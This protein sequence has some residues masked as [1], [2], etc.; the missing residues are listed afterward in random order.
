MLHSKLHKSN[1]HTA[2]SESNSSDSGLDSIASH[3]EPFQG[4]FVL[5][6]TFAA[7]LDTTLPQTCFVYNTSTTAV[8]IS[9]AHYSL[10]V[11]GDVVCDGNLTIDSLTLTDN[12]V[13]VAPESVSATS[14]LLEINNGIVT[15]GFRLWK[16]S[17]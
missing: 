3:A 5:N 1:H 12:V 7:T 15:Q 8:Q 17:I 10:K 2:R 4:D 16:V 9:G 14:L 11:Y 13:S 6:G